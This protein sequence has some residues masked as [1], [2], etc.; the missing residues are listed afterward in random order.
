MYSIEFDYVLH[1]G[2]FGGMVQLGKHWLKQ[3]VEI[4]SNN[5]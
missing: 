4:W 2:S 1:K 5:D 3:I